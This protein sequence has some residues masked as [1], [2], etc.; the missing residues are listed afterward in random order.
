MAAARRAPRFTRKE[1]AVRRGELIEAA[2]ACLSDGGLSAFTIDRICREAGVS[3]GLISHHFDG[4]DGLLLAVY[5]TLTAHLSE[6]SLA[7]LRRLGATPAERLAELI[8]AS[9]RPEI[10]NRRHLRAWLALWSEAATDPRLQAAHRAR[11]A[12][13]R[14]SLANALRA[15]ARERGRAVDAKR[16]ATML[17]GLIDGLWLEWCL[18]PDAVSRKEARAACSELIESRLGPLAA[19]YTKPR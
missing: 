16:L 9:F 13:Y 2:L 3:R 5:E 8:E 11:Y 7:G 6:A 19:D 10:F 14:S 4:K 1:T 15:L 12:D 18:N 17:I